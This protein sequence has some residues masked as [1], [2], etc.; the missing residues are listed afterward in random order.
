MTKTIARSLLSNGVV[1]IMDLAYRSVHPHTTE[2][3]GRK[4]LRDIKTMKD[5]P[6]AV[7]KTSEE[8]KARYARIFRV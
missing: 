6:I 4:P 1:R 7:E 5:D 3:P 8:V 2:L